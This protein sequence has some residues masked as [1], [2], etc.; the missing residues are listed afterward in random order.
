MFVD[1][2]GTG[3]PLET[4]ANAENN[5]LSGAEIHIEKLLSEQ[6]EQRNAA[7]EASLLSDLFVQQFILSECGILLIFTGVMNSTNEV[8]IK[9]I[10]QNQKSQAKEQLI[11]IIHNLYVISTVQ[12]FIKL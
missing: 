4:F 11:Y 2:A 6:R 9:Q 10:L 1:T 7:F 12:E 3:E 5:K 8:N